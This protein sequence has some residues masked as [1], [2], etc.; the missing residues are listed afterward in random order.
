MQLGTVLHL[1][2][3]LIHQLLMLDA[4]I[5]L[6][7]GC[8]EV[9]WSHTHTH[10]YIY[11]HM[12][13]CV[14]LCWLFKRKPRA[15]GQKALRLIRAE[16]DVLGQSGWGNCTKQAPNS[17]SSASAQRPTQSVR[18]PG[19]MFRSAI[20]QRLRHRKKGSKHVQHKKCGHKCRSP[21]DRSPMSGRM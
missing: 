19:S 1:P 10:I 11:R 5:C 15:K 4:S 16:L 17:A 20:A 18:G 12:L 9:A 3:N 8:T 14:D 21:I 2:R 7:N 13:F 6:S